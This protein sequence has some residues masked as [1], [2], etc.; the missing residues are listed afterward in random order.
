MIELFKKDRNDK[1]LKSLHRSNETPENKWI[2][3]LH[4]SL[5]SSLEKALEPVT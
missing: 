1:F 4:A 2:I 5:K 3:G